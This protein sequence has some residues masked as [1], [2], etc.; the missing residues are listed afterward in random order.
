MGVSPHPGVRG[1]LRGQ[2]SWLSQRHSLPLGL[3]RGHLGCLGWKLM[4]ASLVSSPQDTGSSP[5][6]PPPTSHTH[7]VR[8]PQP[9][10]PPNEQ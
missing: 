5:P 3:S 7:L 6:H 2:V 10:V 1:W 8:S 9:P 4:K